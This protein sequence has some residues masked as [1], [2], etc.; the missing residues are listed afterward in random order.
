MNQQV[1]VVI[2]RV[3]T[4]LINN[5]IKHADAD[6]IQIKLSRENNLLNL[7]YIDDGK[8]FDPDELNYESSGMGLYNIL[9]RIRSL[10]GSHSIQSS[11]ESG[12][13]MAVVNV[14]L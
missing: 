12:G 1:E 14:N 7:I 9:S 6:H 5:T 2:Y 4:E 3:V 11:A 13:M 10:N 8:G